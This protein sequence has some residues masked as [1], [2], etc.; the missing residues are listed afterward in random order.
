MI[1]PPVAKPKLAPLV[2]DHREEQLNLQ[3]KVKG[4]CVL[5][6]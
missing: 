5:G 2:V 3:A 1:N 4:E 6:G